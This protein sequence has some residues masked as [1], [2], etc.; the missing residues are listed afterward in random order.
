MTELK[1]KINGTDY[2]GLV[3]KGKYATRK[4]P[5]IGSQYTDLNKVSHVTIKRY[6]GEVSVQIN[7]AKESIVTALC[8]D[9]MD[10]PCTVQYHSFQD[11]A[12]R[13]ATMMPSDESLAEA[14]KYMN[15]EY[16]NTFNLTLTE[17]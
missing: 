2:S 4:S 9:L 1:F 16:I 11:G 14:C 5:V 8:Q 13:T 12:D 15:K 17:L 10:A 7:T 6:I 3:T